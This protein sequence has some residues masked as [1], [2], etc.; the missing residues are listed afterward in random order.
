MHKYTNKLLGG[1]V[2]AGLLAT[3]SLTHAGAVRD[4]NLGNLL[5]GNDD[6]STGV[7][8]MGFTANFFGVSYSQLWVNNNGNV[9]FDGPLST[10]TPFPLLNTATPIIAPFFADVDTRANVPNLN[11]VRYGTTTVDG[12]SA[13]AVTWNLVG[14]Y[15]FGVDRTNTFQLVLIERGDTGAGNFDIEFNY[16]RIQWEAGSASGGSGGLGG[17][18]ARVGYSNGIDSS[19]ELAGS[20]VNGALLDSNL[21]SGLIHNS[22]G[23]DVDGRYLFAARNGN[24]DPNPNPI[25][26]PS[27]AASGMALLAG[28]LGRRVRRA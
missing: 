12:R 9:T 3:G 8:P 4:L 17:S 18:S 27:A 23:S 7:V 14:Y 1:V 16:D 13:F 11:T 22:L 2:L 15:A 25:P 19:F 28:A 5:P 26:L 6:G 24:V 20:A 10:F 21:T